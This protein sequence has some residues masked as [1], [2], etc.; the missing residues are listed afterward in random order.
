MAVDN[1]E[2]EAFLGTNYILALNKLP[3]I[4]RYWR[5]DYLNGNNVIQ[6]TNI[7]NRFCEI[8]QNLHFADNTYD[9]KTDR[10]FKARPVVN[11]LNKKLAEVLSNN[12]KQSIDEYIVRFRGDSGMKHYIKSKSLKL[13]FKFW[14]RCSCKTGYL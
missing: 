4:A 12:K 8:P 1:N 9:D 6:N 7:R 14:I 2:L 5:V 10:G 13:G 3:A 11:Q